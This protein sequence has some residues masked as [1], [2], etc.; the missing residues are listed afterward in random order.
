VQNTVKLQELCTGLEQFG[1]PSAIANLNKQRFVAWNAIFLKQTGF[2]EA[3]ISMLNVGSTVVLS[4][5]TIL[6]PGGTEKYS[7]GLIP[8]VVRA[9]LGLSVLPGY[10]QRSE[11]G[12]AH[13]I[14]GPTQSISE[15]DFQYWEL[16]GR[17]KERV[18]IQQ[19][20]HDAVFSPILT[21]VF[22]IA[23]AKDATNAAEQTEFLQ[24]ASDLLTSTFE[25]V[26]AALEG[27]VS[28]DRGRKR[29]DTFSQSSGRP[30]ARGKQTV[31]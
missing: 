25:V 20:F 27:K 30:S 4:D 6:E 15:S 21:A 22:A 5:S 19:I 14:L 8:C 24:R 7:P 2:S 11:D 23:A 10:I 18:R 31:S 3:E 28:A 12:F 26:G 16:V 13:I 1:L 9:A 29:T 17:E